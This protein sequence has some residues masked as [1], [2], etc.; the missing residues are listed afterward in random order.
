M[1]IDN[2]GYCR[3]CK[4]GYEFFDTKCILFKI[5]KCLDNETIFVRDF[6]VNSSYIDFARNYFYI[7]D[8]S[9]GC[10]RCENNT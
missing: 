6:P 7:R 1:A 8:K 3:I 2:N 9:K 10:N 4:K 5:N